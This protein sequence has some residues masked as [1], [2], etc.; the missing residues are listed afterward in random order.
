LADWHRRSC[1]LLR[2]Y[3]RLAALV[4]AAICNPARDFLLGFRWRPCLQW[5][6]EE[7]HVYVRYGRHHPLLARLRLGPTDTMGNVL[8]EFLPGRTITPYVGAGVFAYQGIVDA[9]WNS[10]TPHRVE[11]LVR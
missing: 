3:A 4:L 7:R 6:H 5:R 11:I 2:S 1:S 9:G 10:M 8:Y